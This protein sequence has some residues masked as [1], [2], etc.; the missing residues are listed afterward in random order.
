M[1]GPVCASKTQE[2]QGRCRAIPLESRHAP[3]SS[4]DGASPA[5]K[6]SWLFCFFSPLTHSSF[7]LE[8]RSFSQFVPSALVNACPGL[9]WEEDTAHG[10][11]V[12]DES[13]LPPSSA[14]TTTVPLWGASSPPW[15]LLPLCPPN[16]QDLC[17]LLVPVFRSM[18]LMETGEFRPAGLEGAAGMLCSG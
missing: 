2:K 9:S 18:V 1:E 16:F 6:T 14:N 12:M 13:C 17:S 3:G 4:R 5:L 8:L 10:W 15:T 7:L 11:D